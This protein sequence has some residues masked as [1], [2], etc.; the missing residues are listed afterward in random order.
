MNRFVMLEL[1]TGLTD[2]TEMEWCDLYIGLL[3]DGHLA[4]QL[5]EGECYMSVRLD[6]G[7][8]VGWMGKESDVNTKGVEAF[9]KQ[10]AQQ[11]LADEAHR[12]GER[13]QRR[14]MFEGET[15]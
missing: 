7:I 15:Q 9:A 10:I 4:Q 2:P 3:R 11:Y 5:S 14:M 8:A 1:R 12:E 13:R 6:D